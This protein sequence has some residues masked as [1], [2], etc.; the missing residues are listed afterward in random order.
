MTVKV[1]YLNNCFE[2]FYD[3]EGITKSNEV[4]MLHQSEGGIIM[5]DARLKLEVSL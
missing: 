4:F 2:Y 5:I 1:I 3:I